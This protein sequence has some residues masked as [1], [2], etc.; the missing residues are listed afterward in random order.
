MFVFVFV[1]SCSVKYMRNFREGRLQV[2]PPEERYTEV[3]LRGLLEEGSLSEEE[4]KAYIAC[5][6]KGLPQDPNDQK[7]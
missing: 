6:S 2:C 4:C 1:N 3:I 5:K 7:I